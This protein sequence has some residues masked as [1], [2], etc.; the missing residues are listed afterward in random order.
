M[1]R[2]CSGGT[3]HLQLEDIHLLT[4]T[5]SDYMQDFVHIFQ[6]FA[7]AH[8]IDYMVDGFDEPNDCIQQ[9]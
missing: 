4:F 5:D 8:T 1:P 6:I 3:R 7:Y 2:L 9:L